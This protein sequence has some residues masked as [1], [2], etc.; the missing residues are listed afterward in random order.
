MSDNLKIQKFK[1]INIKKFY[2]KIKVFSTFVI[3]IVKDSLIQVV[4]YALKKQDRPTFGILSNQCLS[5]IC[6]CSVANTTENFSETKFRRK[7]SKFLVC[8]KIPIIQF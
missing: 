6:I 5:H 1:I 8:G 4:F 3:S 2:Q 7:K